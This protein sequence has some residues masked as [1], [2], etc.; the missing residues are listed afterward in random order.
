MGDYDKFDLIPPVYLLDSKSNTGERNDLLKV[1][2]SPRF[3]RAC[4]KIAFG[5]LC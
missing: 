4:L 1:F 2:L 3:I 5:P